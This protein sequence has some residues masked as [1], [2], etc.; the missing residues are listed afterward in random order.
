MFIILFFKIIGWVWVRGWGTKNH[1]G[2]DGFWEVKMGT[3]N[4]IPIPT[5]LSCLVTHGEKWFVEGRIKWKGLTF[6]VSD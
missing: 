2:G 3:R 1:S 4:Y 6:G 5:L